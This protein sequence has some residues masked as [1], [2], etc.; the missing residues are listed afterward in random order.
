MEQEVEEGI[1]KVLDLIVMVG[2]VEVEALL[3]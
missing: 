2:A 3:R 1:V